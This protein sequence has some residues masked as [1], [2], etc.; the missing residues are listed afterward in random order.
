[1]CAPPG[2]TKFSPMRV[3]SYSS[4]VAPVAHDHYG[5]PEAPRFAFRPIADSALIELPVTTVRLQGHNF[6][7]GGG[8][9]F[10]L[11]PYRLS[12]WA[13]NHVNRTDKR[14]TIFYFHPWEIDTEQPRVENAP[15]KSRVRHYI[16]IDKMESKLQRLF[17]D[18]E[19]TRA[20]RVAA[21]QAGL[22]ALRL[23]I[24]IAAIDDPFVV[25]EIERFLREQE[26]A[27]PFHRPAWMRAIE[28]ASRHRA[29]YLVAR[30]GQRGI[31]GLLPLHHV[32]SPLFGSALVS[33]GFAVGGG[34][35]ANDLET[36][37]QLAD[38]GW[39][40]AEDLNC[41]SL[42]LRAGN[43]A[44][45]RGTG[46]STAR[47]MLVSRDRSRPTMNRSCP[48]FRASSGR[49]Q[50][51]TRERPGSDHGGR[52]EADLKRITAF[53]LKA[54]ETSVR[55]YSR[56]HCSRRCMRHSATMPTY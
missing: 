45:R 22:L 3:I 25:D 54:S 2:R 47:Y 9:F 11:F 14:P 10:R 34:I 12:R 35:L 7:A 6:A 16:N 21:D 26:Q 39:A 38:A 29:H 41:P 37:Q 17:R 30:S 20:D 44:Q 56:V 13:I 8:G 53:M 40:L 23:E 51:S 18:F 4:S 27:T 1:M 55:R 46:M 15:L 50:E 52:D 43:L 42:E 33:S 19:W 36:A 49:S 28:Q 48:P 5:W 31:E 24:D 32:R